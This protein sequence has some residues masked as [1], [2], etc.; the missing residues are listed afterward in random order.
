ML[1][2][3]ASPGVSNVQ[4]A[5]QSVELGPYYGASYG[6]WSAR[7]WQ[8][9]FSIPAAVNPLLD[10]S[11]GNCGQ[12][13][14]DD[15]WFLAGNFGGT[16]V[17]SCTI[18][19]GK[20]IFFPVINQVAYLPKASETLM[21]LRQQ[22]AASI[23]SVTSKSCTLDGVPVNMYRARSPSFSV[24]MPPQGIFAPGRLSPPAQKDT[25]VADG[26]WVL[27]PAL[28]PGKHTL[29]FQAGIPG[30]SLNITYNLT[31]SQP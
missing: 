24:L 28:T 9:A 25:L 18:P 6:E 31:V 7:W 26:Y 10:P 12:R 23:D 27:L 20:P 19:F 14:Y 1:G 17:R 3:L 8:W 15:V 21:D 11:G 22:N 16:T 5:T 2:S 4:A 30:F 29:K 13:Q